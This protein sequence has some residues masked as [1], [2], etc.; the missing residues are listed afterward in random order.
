MLNFLRHGRMSCDCDWV[1]VYL[2][3]VMGP[4]WVLWE[5]RGS[6]R[7]RMGCW[8]CCHCEGWKT[9]LERGSG[10]R[11]LPP[12]PLSSSQAA[13]EGGP[14]LPR[15]SDSR[16]PPWPPAGCAPGCRSPKT[17]T[18][19]SCPSPCRPPDLHPGFSEPPWESCEHWECWGREEVR[20]GG[21]TGSSGS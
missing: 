18:S 1:T 16:G 15:G 13:A 7:M 5:G 10:S 21:E 2:L 17:R 3:Q 19:R 6:W 20:A 4:H 8:D 9:R 12:H 14:R 11:A